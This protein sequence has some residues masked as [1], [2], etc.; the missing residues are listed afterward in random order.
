MF[1]YSETVQAMPIIFAVKIDRLKVYIILLQSDDLALR[2]RSQLRLT[3]DICLTYTIIAISQTVF[4][5]YAF[6]LGMTVELCM[7]IY[8]LDDLDLDTRSQWVGKGKNTALIY[9]DKKA[10][11]KKICYNGRPFFM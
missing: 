3:L 9:L 1:D 7:V 5:L 6:K 11:H 4:K 8:I 2:S 10:S